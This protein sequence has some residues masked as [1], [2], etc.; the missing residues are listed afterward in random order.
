MN[1]KELP[2]RPSLEQ[3]KKQAK[4][5]L[6]AIKS[7][8]ATAIRRWAD[9]WL[10]PHDRPRI[11]EQL[12]ATPIAA[13]ELACTPHPSPPESWVRPAVLVLP[14]KSLDG[15][16]AQERLAETA[17][18]LLVGV[19]PRRALID[20]RGPAGETLRPAVG[21]APLRPDKGAQLGLSKGFLPPAFGYFFFPPRAP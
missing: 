8:D 12:R 7:S 6:K 2:A 16:D 9:Q 3:Y 5:L 17:L 11:T 19:D 20:E 18:G 1:P 4:D 15:C 10:A 13:V 21:V 14:L